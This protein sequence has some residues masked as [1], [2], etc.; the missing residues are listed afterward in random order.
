MGAWNYIAPKLQELAPEGV[1]VCYVGRPPMA[2]P[3]EGNSRVHKKEQERI[4]TTA[5]THK[6]IVNV[7]A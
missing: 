5:L 7:N 3:S 6:A 2:S 4:V 1:K